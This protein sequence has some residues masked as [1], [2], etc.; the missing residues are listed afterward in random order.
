MRGAL[1]IGSA[2]FR[3]L[4][5]CLR[6]PTMYTDWLTVTL[7]SH[8]A[9]T[10][11]A[12]RSYGLRDVFSRGLKRVTLCF[13]IVQELLAVHLPVLHNHFAAHHIEV[14][15][16][17]SGWF[18]TLFSSLNTLPLASAARVW[19]MYLTHGWSAVFRLVLALLKRIE[20]ELGLRVAAAEEGVSAGAA[21]KRSRVDDFSA[22]L[23]LL[24]RMPTRIVSPAATL[25]DEAFDPT[26]CPDVN[27]A[28]LRRLEAEFAAQLD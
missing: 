4:K 24:H 20:T 26:F 27:D 12:D 3:R 13:W 22:T 1:A 15:M 21:K 7:V 14:H 17:A 23:E 11:P 18:M 6:A 8:R 25:V 28:L 19:D 9:P 2:A 5:L 16:F 10:P